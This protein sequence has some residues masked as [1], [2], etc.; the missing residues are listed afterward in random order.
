M[1]FSA[2]QLDHHESEIV[3]SPDDSGKAIEVHLGFLKINH[4]YHI[5]IR[6]K[7]HLGEDITSDPLQNVNVQLLEAMPSEDGW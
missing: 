5:K 1:R 7:D 4:E 6:I 3:V 2:E